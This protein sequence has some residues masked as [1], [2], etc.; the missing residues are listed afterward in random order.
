M[1]LTNLDT[2]S[3]SVV[4]IHHYLV[5]STKAFNFESFISELKPYFEVKKLSS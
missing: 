2:E 3:L 1:F 5:K 4:P